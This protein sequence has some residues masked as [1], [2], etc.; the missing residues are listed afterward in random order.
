MQFPDYSDPDTGFELSVV[1]SQLPGQSVT[2]AAVD[3]GGVL[4]GPF[5][6]AL[7]ATFSVELLTPGTT[8]L[9]VSGLARLD[10]SSGAP[11]G[12]DLGPGSLTVN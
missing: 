3:L 9:L 10:D 7:L 1:L 11:L 2:I 12:P 4:Q 6:R 5:D 8:H